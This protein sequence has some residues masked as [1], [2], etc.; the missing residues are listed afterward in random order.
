MS[1][2]KKLIE[3][4]DFID[5][6]HNELSGRINPN[7]IVNYRIQKSMLDVDD[8][9]KPEPQVEETEEQLKLHMSE[10]NYCIEQI[11]SRFANK[12]PVIVWYPSE[13]YETGEIMGISVNRLVFSFIVYVID[14]ASLHIKKEYL[15]NGSI[16]YS[17]MV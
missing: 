4:S 9:K 6:L 17:T 5:E 13:L 2:I 1:D 10:I 16:R 3:E 12:Q 14:D 7:S 11:L 8:E 15:T